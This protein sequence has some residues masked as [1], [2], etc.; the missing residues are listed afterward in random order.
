MNSKQKTLFQSWGNHGNRQS[1]QKQASNTKASLH[2]SSVGGHGDVIDLCDEDLDED[3]ALLIQALDESIQTANINGFTCGEHGDKPN[4]SSKYPQSSVPFSKANTSIRSSSSSSSSSRLFNTC[5]KATAVQGNN[6]SVEEGNLS[7]GTEKI[8][9]HVPPSSVSLSHIPDL[10]G[11]DKQAGQLWIYPTNYQVR[12]YQFNIVQQCLYNNTLVTLPTGLGKTFIAAVVMYNYYRWYPQCKIVFMAPTK[13]LVAQQIHACYNI[14]GIPPE[15]TAEMTGNMNPAERRRTWKEKRVF[16]LTPQVITNDLSRGTCPADTVKCLVIDE[17]HKALGN[18]AYCQVVRELVK[19]TREFRVVALSATPGSDL[20][21]VQQVITNLLLSHIEL[22][23]EQCI[24][25]KPYTH[26]RKVEKIVVALGEELLMIQKKYIQVMSVVV[27]RLTH[28]QVLYSQREVTSLSKFFILK[29]REAFRQ[30]PPP[31]MPSHQ[32]GVVEGDFALALSLYHGYELLQLHGLRSLY[33]FLDGIINGDKGYGRTKTELMKNGNFLEIMDILKT[34][35]A[36]DD[37]SWSS[38]QKKAS[39]V[40]GHPKMKKLEQVALEHFNTSHQATRVMIFSQY[41]DSVQEITDMLNLHRPMI[42]AIS[43]IG[44]SS[45]GKSTKGFTQ[46]EQLKVMKAFREGGYNTLVSTCVGEEGLDIGDVDLIICFDAHKSPIRLVQRMGRTGRK[47]QG[48]IVMLVTAGKEEQVYNQSQYS[49]RSIHKG[50]LN[51]ARSLHLYPNNPRMLPDG[52]APA[53][54]K[55]FITVKDVAR[56]NPVP[57]DPGETQQRKLLT[58]KTGTRTGRKLLPKSEEATITEEEY[59]ELKAFLVSHFKC[60]PPRP[61]LLYLGSQLQKETEGENTLSLT[62]WTLWQNR[63]QD[64]QFVDHS[65]RSEHLVELIEFLQLQETLPGNEDHYGVEMEM[66]LKREDVLQPG[67]KDDSE[68]GGGILRFCTTSGHQKHPTRGKPA[69]LTARRTVG[70]TEILPVIEDWEGEREDSEGELPECHTTGMVVQGA[71]KQEQYVIKSISPQHAKAKNNNKIEFHK[72]KMKQDLNIKR[73]KSKKFVREGSLIK[74][75]MLDEGDFEED[76]PVAVIDMKQDEDSLHCDEWSM[77]LNLGLERENLHVTHTESLDVNISGD[78]QVNSFILQQPTDVVSQGSVSNCPLKLGTFMIRTAPPLQVVDMVF[79]DLRNEAV[80]PTLDLKQLVCEWYEES[81]GPAGLVY[82]TSREKQHEITFG[83]NQEKARLCEGSALCSSLS[84]TTGDRANVLQSANQGI[85]GISDQSGPDSDIH[86]FTWMKPAPSVPESDTAKK[87]LSVLNLNIMKNIPSGTETF[88][89]QGPEK[90]ILATCDKACGDIID[91][92]VSMNRSVH[93]RESIMEIDDHRIIRSDKP[94][95]Q[96]QDM[97]SLHNMYT[98]CTSKETGSQ[99]S[100]FEDDIMNNKYPDVSTPQILHIA[101]SPHPEVLTFTQALLC[102]QSSE[103]HPQDQGQLVVEDFEQEEHPQDQGQLVVEDFEQEEHPQDQGQ[104]VVEDFEQEEHPQDQGQLVVEDFEQ[105]EHPQD[106][107]QLVVEDFEQEEHPQDQGQLVVEDFEQEEHPQ[108]QGQLVVE[109]FEQ[110]EHPQDQGQLVVE[111]FEQ[112]EHPQDQGQL[113]VEDFEQEEHPQDQGQLV[114]EDFEQE[115]HPQDQGQLVVEDFEQEEHPQD[116]GQLVVEDFEQEE[117]PQD[118]GQLVVEDLKQETD[119]IDHF[120]PS[121][122][123]FDDATDH[124]D[125]YQHE[126]Q[127]YLGSSSSDIVKHSFSEI[128]MNR[129]PVTFVEGSH[130]ESAPG[131][132]YSEKQ[133]HS[134]VTYVTAATQ[135]HSDDNGCDFDFPHFD[136]EF[137]FD[138]DI[139]P[140]SPMAA[141]TFSQMSLSR[142]QINITSR[143]KLNF[144]ET[145]DLVSGERDEDVTT[146]VCGVVGKTSNEPQHMSLDNPL[147]DDLGTVNLTNSPEAAAL[148]EERNIHQTSASKADMISSSVVFVKADRGEDLTPMPRAPFLYSPLSSHARSSTPKAGVSKMSSCISYLAKVATPVM[149]KVSSMVRTAS[150]GMPDSLHSTLAQTN[151]LSNSP[152]ASTPSG[153]QEACGAEHTEVEEESFRL[154]RKRKVAAILEDTGDSFSFQH[155]QESRDVKVLSFKTPSRPAARKK[156]KM[157]LDF[158]SD[159]ENECGLSSSSSKSWS[160]ASQ[161]HHSSSH[162]NDEDDFQLSQDT[163][164]NKVVNASKKKRKERKTIKTRQ[165]HCFLDE[166]AILSGSDASSDED[167]DSNDECLEASFVNDDTQMSQDDV[168]IHAVYLKSVRSPIQNDGFRLQA[169]HYEKDVFSQV[170]EQD[171]EYEEDSFCVGED[172]QETERYDDEL[173]LLDD[174]EEFYHYSKRKSSKQSKPKKCKYIVGKSRKRIRQ[175]SGS[176]SEEETRVATSVLENTQ[177]DGHGSHLLCSQRNKPI[178]KKV[179]AIL[180]SSEEEIS[181]KCVAKSLHH[182]SHTTSLGQAGRSISPQQK[183]MS[184]VDTDMLRQ[185]RLAKQKQ[186][187]E[188]FRQKMSKKNGRYEYRLVPRTDAPISG[189]AVDTSR[190][191]LD[192][193]RADYD[194]ASDKLSSVIPK[195]LPNDCGLNEKIVILVDSREISGAQDIVSNLRL[196]HGATVLARQLGACDYIISNRTAVD[197]RQ[198]SDFSNGAHRVKLIDRIQQ[199]REL[200]DR[201]CLVVEKDRVKPGEEKSAKPSHRTK[202][203]DWIQSVLVQTN[204]RLFF[205]ENQAETAALMAQLAQLEK[206]KKMNISVPVDVGQTQEQGLKFYTSIPNVSYVN[207][208]NLC[209]NY[210]CISHF[211]SSC[212]PQTVSI[213]GKMSEVRAAEVC[214]YLAHTFDLQMLPTGR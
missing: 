123:L 24:D 34:K 205:T 196:Q 93:F 89:S 15:D 45:T 203:Y 97:N 104:L 20:K 55:M 25:I 194:F 63:L 208:L 113:V 120:M 12:D 47:R 116:Q 72:D 142:S 16:F 100:Y 36:A 112:E 153:P 102:V 206:K 4:I 111:D 5:H 52:L 199:M 181:P 40:S 21:A 81:Y 33:N 147:A 79:S 110:E 144:K 65:R 19:Y 38:T 17:A 175:I 69:G 46:K 82:V 109:D 141:Q 195:P 53:C 99:H 37:S 179:A 83:T 209:Y 18:H 160:R 132:V 43:F 95:K 156:Q 42:M 54:H 105:E 182:A 22:R 101:R 213:R 60:P 183:T 146:M 77:D 9:V 200:Y 64:T 157:K 56:L 31:S 92:G 27:K 125:G 186:K 168:D 122:N 161:P 78:Q 96:E 173:D 159:E 23:T 39:Y 143:K 51:G 188:E 11:F 41:R 133:Q 137:D 10:P 204:V 3:D 201:C 169:R 13:P 197:R 170:P 73:T 87:N 210:R 211:L 192:I 138:D 135:P 178:R 185:E 152:S 164:D 71:D 214:C 8:D 84:A 202:Y 103:E 191:L 29:A 148:T 58:G 62:E 28:Q 136:L 106:Q 134:K 49:K 117:H 68:Q 163:G 129:E 128:K 171:N 59:S 187:Q 127:T 91:L 124:D 207:A 6:E 119:D 74:P 57:K 48:R 115:E 67:E 114:V 75:I 35:Y 198:L 118:Q 154:V 131:M 108:D 151:Q 70:G 32:Y 26:E 130:I 149:N 193:S 150:G 7:V 90:T 167:W 107:G 139:I 50:I 98:D 177:A 184:V 44:Q 189:S 162:T 166:E 1:S 94:N 180:S 158:S 121:F 61:T 176:S 126:Q 30:N 2:T 155:G 88:P 86:T 165:G 14:M 145:D 66:Y 212:T 190:R 85:A 172:F 80:L 174:F 140:P 76:A